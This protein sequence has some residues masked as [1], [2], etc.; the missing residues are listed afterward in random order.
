MIIKT[1]KP[2]QKLQELQALHRRTSLNHPKIQLIKENLARCLAGY[3]GECAIDYHLTFLEE[4][5]YFIFHDI[6]LKVSKHYFQIDTLLLSRKLAFNLEVKNFAG[7]LYFDEENHQL[8]RLLD[9][10]K[11]AFRD[12]LI[13]IFFQEQHLKNWFSNNGYPDLPV[14]SLVVI[15]N[16]STI[17]HTTSKKVIHSEFLP[18]K[19]HQL[20]KNYSENKLSDKV[21][22][23]LIRQIKKQDTPLQTSL[24][25]QF[26]LS[27][28]ELL[29]G[30]HCPKCN[31]IPLIRTYGNW[32]CPRCSFQSSDAHFHSIK[33]YTLLINDMFTN[34]EIRSFL[35]I[36]NAQLMKRLLHSPQILA[37][38]NKNARIY[39]LLN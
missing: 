2:P 21:L 17:I 27:E 3:R 22:K 30:V 32:I 10:Q 36:S 13:Q 4:K 29:K 1:R 5:N 16:P 28:D 19:I 20:E 34:R 38:G 33:D 39:K 11:E 24:I 6:R 31:F 25:E 37:L 7:E 15:S 35:K 12:P 8:I 18:I 9:G 26:E 23:K 14:Q